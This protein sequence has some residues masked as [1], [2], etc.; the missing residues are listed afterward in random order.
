M[1]LFDLIQKYK[2]KK[3]VRL[4]IHDDQEVLFEDDEIIIN[5]PPN[6][7]EDEL[8][9][10]V[11]RVKLG[12]DE[13]LLGIFHFQGNWTDEEGKRMSH[14]A[15]A[16]SPLQKAWSYRIVRECDTELYEKEIEEMVEMWEVICPDN[17]VE[18]GTP[19]SI[20]AVE[21]YAILAQDVNNQVFCKIVQ[22]NGSDNRMSIYIERLGFYAKRT[23]EPGLYISL[24]EALQPD[25]TV[26]LMNDNGHKYFDIRL[27]EGK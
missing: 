7:P 22:Q 25:Y 15:A 5:M 24:V 9:E 20:I 26:K 14:F 8:V 27:K 4:Q 13:P 11:A 2:I 3:P 12:E 19:E 23:P 18:A 1:E 21:L 10:L 6:A 16:C 17:R